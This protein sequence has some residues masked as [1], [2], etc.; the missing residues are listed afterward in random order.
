MRRHEDQ[1]AQ[2]LVCLIASVFFNIALYVSY[3]DYFADSGG[4][5]EQFHSGD[6]SASDRIALLEL[7]GTVM[8]PFTERILAVIKQAGQDNRVKGTI[9]V[10]DSP[11]GL[12]ADSHQIYH[13]LQELSE[14][15]PVF[16]A[17][18]RMAASGGYYVAM[19][20]GKSTTIYAE[21]TTWTGSIGVIIPRYSA[22]ALAEKIGVTSEPLATG[23]YKDS[24][25]PFRKMSDDERAVWDAIIQDAFD[26]FVDVIVQ[27][28]SNLDREAVTKLATGQVY[29]AGQA[30][31]N[32]LIDR[33]GFLDEAIEDLQTH[34]RLESVRVVRYES[35]ARLIDLV[36]GMQE[37]NQRESVIRD[38]LE[39]TVPQAMYFCS[40]APAV[41]IRFRAAN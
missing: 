26:R 24:L 36:V 41:P 1:V 19:G 29:T 39:A 6:R 7:T 35:P 13:A 32:G 31:E 2:L 10:I 33:I 5:D 27:N 11:G 23:P 8:P 20:A 34:L 16:V 17:M 15:K 14:K 18:K 37:T 22:V 38:L 4:P 40:W 12:V 28:R 21:P 9:L 25:S 30:K 3:H